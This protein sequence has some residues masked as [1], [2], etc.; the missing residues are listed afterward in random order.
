MG[1][2]E[3]QRTKQKQKRASKA[4]ARKKL[5]S[6]A[7]RQV[8]IWMRHRRN[9]IDK[10][11]AVDAGDSPLPTLGSDSM[12]AIPDCQGV[13]ECC[14][15]ANILV[16]PSDVLRIVK[17]Q[18]IR[19]TFGIR[20][21]EDLFV[22]RN[23]DRP[24]LHMQVQQVKNKSLVPI[25]FAVLKKIEDKNGEEVLGCPFFSETDG[26][27]DCLL[28]GDCLSMCVSSPVDRLLM[29]KEKGERSSFGY[30]VDDTVCLGCRFRKSHDVINYSVSDWVRVCGAELRHKESEQFLGFLSWLSA[31]RSDEES[32]KIA[33]SVLYDFDR[34]TRMM[35]SKESVDDIE[36]ERPKDVVSILKSAKLIVD[37]TKAASAYDEVGKKLEEDERGQ[38]DRGSNGSVGE[39]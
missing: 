12:V 9:Y 25:C 17:N 19:E 35:L 10:S 14:F 34:V 1:F 15:G 20:T 24:L 33:A 39:P 31:S 3:K 4:I 13:G 29:P 7:K 8:A 5:D 37:K 38:S 28:G 6:M 32:V 36:A 2:K 30:A 21:T 23:G 11:E 22:D 27:S 18:R 16:E 26:V